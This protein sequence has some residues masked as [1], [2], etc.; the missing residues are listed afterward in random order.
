M[1]IDSAAPVITRD[2]ILIHAPIETIWGI[3]T[4]VAAW[5]SWQP[6]VDGVEA[7]GPLAVG[8]VFRWQTAGLDITSTV[9]EVDPPHRIVWGGLRAGHCRR[10]RLVP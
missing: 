4:D 1:E 6:D 3:Q 7:E 5:P 10:P 2:E 8:S 9:E